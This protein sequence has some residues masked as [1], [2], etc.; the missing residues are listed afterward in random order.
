MVPE[1]KPILADRVFLAQNFPNPFNAS[2]VFRY[3]LPVSGQ[4]KINIINLYGHTISQM[5]H[6]HEQVGTHTFTWDASGFESGVY[7]CTV[8]ANGFAV[9]QKMLLLK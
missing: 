7:V 1:S 5:I 4:V 3:T 9:S 8:E 6:E 2:T